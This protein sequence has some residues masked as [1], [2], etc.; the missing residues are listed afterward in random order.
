MKRVSTI[1]GLGLLALTLFPITAA[2]GMSIGVP[3][4]PPVLIPPTP[5]VPPPP[6]C[7]PPPSGIV[8]WWPA[9]NNVV[10]II[11]G[12]NG[13]LINGAS[14]GTGEVGT[15]F[16]FTTTNGGVT[17]PASPGLDVGQ[18][19]G[20][21]VEGWINP[22]DLSRREE[23]V[24]WNS[25]STNQWVPWGVHV[26]I[27]GPG[28]LGLG[29]GNLFSD[30][31][32]TDGNVH[33]IMAP[34]GTITANVFQHIA[35]TYDKTSGVATLYCNGAIVAQQNLGQ[36]TPQTSYDFNI[37]RR[38]AGDSIHSM[39]GA[40]DEVG[41]YSRALSSNEIAAIYLAGNAGK[42]M[43]Q[44]VPP[45]AGIVAWWQAE[46]NALDI[47]G[48]NNGSVPAG[49]T[50]APGEVGQA[51]NF[52]GNANI[53]V[54]NQPALNPTNQLTVEC[55]IYPRARAAFTWP[56][57]VV[58]KDGECANR[59]YILGIDNNN[60]QGTGAGIFESTVWLGSGAVPVSGARVVQTN[61]WYHVAVTYDGALL[62]LYV[63]GAVDGQV[64][65]TGPIVTGSE[66]VRLGGGAPGG[67]PPYFF[68]GLL[69]EPAIYNR[70]LASNE[71][72]AIYLAGSAGKCNNGPFPPAIFTPPMNQTV[73]EGGEADFSVT[74]GGAGPLSYQWTFN[75]KKISGAASYALSLP[76]V[77]PNQ[78]GGYA[79]I[80]TGAGG[81]VTSAPAMLTVIT[82]KILIYSYSGSE[83]TTAP[84]QETTYNYSG[85]MF[86]I[87]DT[88][89]TVFVG[90]ATINGKKQYWVTTV[91]DYLCL[92][93]T[94]SFGRT[95]T[96]LGR[97]GSGFDLNG[98]PHLW[99]ALHKGQNASLLIG[100]KKTYSFPN[101]FSY[102]GA[103]AYPNVQAGNLAAGDMVLREATSS[104]SFLQKNTQAANDG[105][106]TVSDL[107]SAL[108]K[109]LV[110]QGYQPQ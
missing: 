54:P 71:I 7:T 39:L 75:G 12:H 98:Q 74:V 65:V 94:G 103:Q 99:F 14:F 44:C 87:P 1:I 22:A 4:P 37:G 91:T 108:V 73:V 25:G 53:D 66:P 78:A 62:K 60:S 76:D 17:I 81:S 86:F 33:W 24:E 105:G 80:V 16:S 50:F 31:H 85:E 61:T 3:P 96:L 106:Q 82:Q 2:R 92:K 52:T 109:S 47:I 79:V 97:S 101:T 89:N 107:V 10:D 69:D 59:Q 51:F 35:L 6:S 30:V 70:A 45:P 40:I 8:A 72:A 58:T 32:D 46:S 15:G 48:G 9:E 13:A 93:V 84:G 64:A 77:H 28:E 19:D 90:W 95:Y 102:S 88:T 11:G 43:P 5:P 67:C 38:P 68:D 18:G 56:Q 42:C 34:G 29:A 21:T 23:F 110:K 57:D 20:M 63:N 26:Q 27:L 83:K 55:W 36:F 100:T 49:V 104:Y 41:L